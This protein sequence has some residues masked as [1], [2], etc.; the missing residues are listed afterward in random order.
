M[1]KK[2]YYHLFNV[3]TDALK[4]DDIIVLK[5]I[6]IQGQVETEEMYM[7]NCDDWFMTFPCEAHF[8][9]RIPNFEFKKLL[10]F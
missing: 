9:F 2:M 5:E 3:I 6:L 4:E 7:N 8:E 10:H 1:Y